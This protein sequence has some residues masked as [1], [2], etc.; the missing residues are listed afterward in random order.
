M[1][2]SMRS[3][4]QQLSI[5]HKLILVIFGAATLVS[6]SASLVETLVHAK[7]IRQDEIAQTQAQMRVLS[8][9][10]VKI[11]MFPDIYQT[12]DV[13]AKLR[14][15]PLIFNVYL[16][17]RK[18][19]LAFRYE[20]TASAIMQP[21]PASVGREEFKEGF[22]LMSLPM[23]YAGGEYGSLFVRVS[24]KHL[25]EKLKQ[26]YEVIIAGIPALLIVSYLLAIWLQR[27]FS[28]PIITLAHRLNRIADEGDFDVH[29]ESDEPNE[30]GSLYRSVNQLL[31][32]IRETQYRL[33]QG[34]A[35]LDGII[36]IAGSGIISIDED[37]RIILFNR[38]AEHIFGYSPHEVINRPLS[39]LLP[40][41]F[42]KQHENQIDE[43]STAEVDANSPMARVD[44][45][46]LRK[47]GEEFPLEAVISK[48]MFEGKQIF[49]VAFNDV[50]QRRQAERELA[51]YRSHLEEIV[52][53]RTSE[54]RAKNRELEAFS[55]SIAHD[56]RAPLRSITSFS[57]ILQED[58]GDKLNPEETEH[59]SR[60]IKAGNRM[61][62][63]I[64][65]ILDLARIGRSQLLAVEVDLSAM[66]EK[67]VQHLQANE[68]GRTV[69]WEI[70]PHLMVRGD[71][72]LLRLMMDNLI[73]NA[74]KYTSKNEQAIIS[75]G[76]I[77]QQGKRVFY[78]RDNGVGFDMQYA[79][80]LFGVF[81]RLHREEEFEGTGI[82]LA[83]V[84][85]IVQLHGGSIWAEAVLG[86]GATFFFT[87]P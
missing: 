39:M 26:H 42:R 17:N 57:Q 76:V 80:Q 6:V 28:E 10:F 37:H 23:E 1:V 59:L 82:G 58:A 2:A 20:K 78:V 68:P 73:G 35:R 19:E 5:K 44:I 33:Q 46:G 87:L 9:D 34:E 31:K 60:I 52:D 67:I 77:E 75:F 24:T 49:T 55:Y 61:A 62:D 8:Q 54:L 50:S 36:A 13:V 70:Q 63:L 65:D 3:W 16:Y 56:L 83:T 79:S 11:A 48:M 51:A 27:Y 30:V 38:E 69:K 40:E 85:R 72:Q 25:E 15:F 32:T 4:F 41:R 21:P 45:Y 64:D 22:L 7:D 71:S 47:N 14:A 18:G 43:F 74:W 86:K 53:E 84:Q 66:V 12:A 81:Q 29:I